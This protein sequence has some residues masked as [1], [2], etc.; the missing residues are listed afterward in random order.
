MIVYRGT[1]SQESGPEKR[2]FAGVFFAAKPEVAAQYGPYLAKYEI[3][4]QRLLNV[5][6]DEAVRL[7]FAHNGEEGDEAIVDTFAFPDKWW[8]A[9]LKAFGYTGTRFGDD[10]F[11]YDLT[12]LKLL[13]T[14]VAVP[15]ES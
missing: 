12:D 4:E 14:G 5:D 8:V 1:P 3:P 2:D 6:S 7:A 11:I 10:V 15:R 9:I 13:Q